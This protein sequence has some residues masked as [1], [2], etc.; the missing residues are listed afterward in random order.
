MPLTVIV[1]FI[2]ILKSV[3]VKEMTSDNF[4]S[5]KDKEFYTRLKGGSFEQDVRKVYELM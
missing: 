5:R 4:C 2:M 3:H 1:V